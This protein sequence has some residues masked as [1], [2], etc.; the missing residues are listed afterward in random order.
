MRH[1]ISPRFTKVEIE[2]KTGIDKSVIRLEID[3]IVEIEINHIEAEEI[4]IESIDQIIEVDHE[5][6]IDMMIGETTIDMTIGKIA[7][8]KM[9]DMTIIGE[10]ITDP[11][12]GQI[13][14]EKIIGN[15]DIKLEAKVGKILEIITEIIQ[16]KDLREV[17]IEAE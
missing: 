10:T 12:I 5:I 13:M 9:R 11:L 16:G 3:H 15:R 7:T 8:D 4:K 14:E 1:N 6:T 2:A 17:Y